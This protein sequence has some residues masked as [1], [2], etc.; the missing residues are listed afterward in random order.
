MTTEQILNF[1]DQNPQF[2]L[3]AASFSKKIVNGQFTEEPSLTLQVR[4]KKPLQEVPADQIIPTGVYIDGFGWI[5]TDVT[6][7]IVSNLACSDCDISAFS[8][9]TNV[10][11][12]IQK[13]REA[14]RPLA[15]GVSISTVPSGVGDWKDAASFSKN[16]HKNKD[17]VGTFGF[18]AIDELDGSIVGVTNHH[19]SAIDYSFGISGGGTYA[20]QRDL[21]NPTRF[22]AKTDNYN[23]HGH[24]IEN[25][26]YLDFEEQTKR[27]FCRGT[28]FF[29]TRYSQG[30]MSGVL[31]IGYLK[32]YF[33]FAT[34]NNTIDA[35]VIGLHAVAALRYEARMTASNICSIPPNPPATLAVE[36]QIL[37]ADSWKLLNH[38]AGGQKYYPFATTE[39]INSMTSTDFVNAGT[40][41]NPNVVVAGRTSG[42]KGQPRN[43]NASRR[44]DSCTYRV[45]STNFIANTYTAA[46]TTGRITDAIS[47]QW[48]DCP[49]VDAIL[50]GDSGSCLL[51]KFNGI[52]KIVGLIYAGNGA[53]GIACRI[54]FIAPLLKIRPYVGQP[55]RTS[56]ALAQDYPVRSGKTLVVKNKQSLPFFTHTDGRTYYQ[57]GTTT[58]ASDL[59]NLP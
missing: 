12:S 53:A 57:I 34:G 39:E 22:Q 5:K 55:L 6:Q 35:A 25:A 58:R 26:G 16:E 9:L 54:D 4:K 42:L 11:P 14:L 17:V 31:E 45:T 59:N 21:T 1:I 50:G 20:H 2:D 19:V 41:A 10:D 40:A 7:G 27:V 33:P 36:P 47:F 38:D 49:N 46:R 32:R 28:N 3:T 44:N 24:K 52:W 37:G 48:K 51:G 18:I 23:F 8:S 29:A 56:S 30:G 15:G 13:H 43:A